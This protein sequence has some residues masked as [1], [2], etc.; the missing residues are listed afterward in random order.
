[1]INTK[2]SWSC[3]KY[4]RHLVINY[5]LKVLSIGQ[6]KVLSWWQCLTRS[7]GISKGLQFILREAQISVPHLKASYCEISLKTFISR[8]EIRTAQFTLWRPW[9]S[10]QNF[11]VVHPVVISVW[12]KDPEWRPFSNGLM[13][14]TENRFK[15][16]NVRSPIALSSFKLDI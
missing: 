4:N 9:M 13:A 11:I 15:Q 16:E 6:I 3:L 12:T 2:N 5:W 7:E 8:G 10:V 14:E 1:M